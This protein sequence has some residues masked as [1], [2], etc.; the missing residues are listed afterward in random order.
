LPP[1]PFGGLL[2]SRSRAPVS[3]VVVVAIAFLGLPH[4]Y[5]S[6]DDPPVVDNLLA[7]YGPLIRHRTMRRLYT[8]RVPGDA[9][10]M[11]LLT[12]PGV[13]LADALAMDVGPIGLVCM[14]GGATFLM[15]SLAA[16]ELLARPPARLL[17]M[18][19]DSTLI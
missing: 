9:C 2:P 10:W 8:A 19:G 13:F 7:S 12:Y 18:A 11:G 14:A 4:H 15:V 1:V 5:L 6:A 3:A 17:V 16:G